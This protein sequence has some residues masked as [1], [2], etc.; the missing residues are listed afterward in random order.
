MN[1]KNSGGIV[2]QILAAANLNAALSWLEE[3]LVC[4]ECGVTAGNL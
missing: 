3:I 1:N 4:S 2:S